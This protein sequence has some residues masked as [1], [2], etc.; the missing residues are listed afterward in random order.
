MKEKEKKG[1]K[2]KSIVQRAFEKSEPFLL[3]IAF[4]VPVLPAAYVFA[5]SIVCPGRTL[6]TTQTAAAGGGGDDCG[7]INHHPTQPWIPDA[8]IIPLIVVL[9][10]VPCGLCAL[11]LL[12]ASGSWSV[13]RW[14]NKL[15]ALIQLSFIAITA[16]I[17]IAPAANRHFLITL[18]LYTSSFS[19]NSFPLH[20]NSSSSPSSSCS[21]FILN[22]TVSSSSSSS[23]SS[24]VGSAD[25]D[26]VLVVG[27]V[28][29][30]SEEIALI[31]TKKHET[32]S[33]YEPPQYGL[34][35][36]GSD[37]L[38]SAPVSHQQHT[39][40]SVISNS[41]SVNMNTTITMWWYSWEVCGMEDKV[42]YSVVGTVVNRE[43]EV[44][45]YPIIQGEK[46]HVLMNGI[47]MSDDETYFVDKRPFLYCTWDSNTHQCL[48][49]TQ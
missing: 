21:E 45:E 22:F 31:V 39:S 13:H 19:F 35:R 14:R 33:L 47:Q 28:L 38:M 7:L 37:V 12:S 30:G 18:P 3:V 34:Y 46:G 26:G 11:C 15:M 27:N 29:M 5:T 36:V 42:E 8:A 25:G 6:S 16:I 32:Q 24:I 41:N 20:N 17:L 40:S 48:S 49:L 1:T 2:K 44:E 9:V 43:H 4:I 23:S 10:I